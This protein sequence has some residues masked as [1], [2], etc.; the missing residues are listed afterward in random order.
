MRKNILIVSGRTLFVQAFFADN[1]EETFSEYKKTVRPKF[2]KALETHLKTN[3]LSTSGPYVIGKNFT[4]ADIVIYQL[5]HD[6]PLALD[7]REALKDYPR[8][9][10][11]VDAV[12][13]RPNIKAFMQS[14]RYLG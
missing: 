12:E 9:M 14:D 4:Y 5:C 6:D 1:K 3:N 11:L 7:G 8:L 2:L 13:E 10:E